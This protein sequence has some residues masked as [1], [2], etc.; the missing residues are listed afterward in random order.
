[1]RDGKKMD[2][3]NILDFAQAL[4]NCKHDLLGDWYYDPW[5]WPEMEFVMD[6]KQVHHLVSRLNSPS[7]H[8]AA[9]IEVVKENFGIRPA[10]V[11]DPIDRLVYQALVD[12][13]SKKIIGFLGKWVFGW[14]LPLADPSPGH[15]APNNKQWEFYRNT[16]LKLARHFNYPL[17]TDIVSF[18]ASVPVE[19]LIEMLIDR[20]G[21]N[22][23]S[24]RTAEMLRNWNRMLG[25][26]GLPQRFQASAVLANMYLGTVDEAL[27]RLQASVRIEEQRRN[28]YRSA[29]WMDDIWVF[30]RSASDLRRTQLELN[31]RVGDLGL[32]LNYAKTDV[33][34]GDDV[35]R[36]VAEYD[37]S[38]IDVAISMAEL[39]PL[40]KELVR[41]KKSPSHVSGACQ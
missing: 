35:R 2:W 13:Q 3:L 12:K 21:R 22:K 7:A 31:D 19:E 1:M 28:W 16:L 6:P 14:R 32:N 40:E 30:G 8:Y 4:K 26:S 39:G 33:F 15:Y 17:T 24:L 41:L 38:Y 5:G 25:R 11:M 18:F 27:G 10:I 9:K 37:L 36:K 20:A 34:E 29:R 23:L